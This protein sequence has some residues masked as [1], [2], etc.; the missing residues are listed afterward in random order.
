MIEMEIYNLTTEFNLIISVSADRLP[1]KTVTNAVEK[2]NKIYNDWI[3]TLSIND[4]LNL[5]SK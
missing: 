3:Y 1:E 5:T 4:G 2:L